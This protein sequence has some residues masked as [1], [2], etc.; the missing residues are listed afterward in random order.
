MFSR[1]IFEA[2][3]AIMLI[4]ISLLILFHSNT[5]SAACSSPDGAESQTRYD[6]AAHKLFYCNGSAWIEEGPGPT[7][8]LPEGCLEGQIPS[9][10]GT[11]WICAEDEGGSGG[12]GYT[13][14]LVSGSK[15]GEDCDLSGGVALEISAGVYVCY[16]AV[17]MLEEDQLFGF[18]LDTYNCPSGWS[19]YQN[20]TKT[21]AKTCTAGTSCTAPASCTSAGHDFANTARET[22]TYRYRNDDGC[23]TGTC[24]AKLLAMGCI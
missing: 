2:L 22:C 7:G 20:W 13:G 19:A 18:G 4:M 14:P 21:Q 8:G 6:F 16:F 9:W 24:R 5:A 11:E 15:T 10:S 1:F 17:N 12:S 23:Q 3:P